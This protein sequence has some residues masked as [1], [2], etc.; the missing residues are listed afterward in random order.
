MSPENNLFR[1]FLAQSFRYDPEANY[2]YLNNAK[3]GCSTIKAALWKHHGKLNNLDLPETIPPKMNHGEGFWSKDYA[4]I[5]SQSPYIFS[6]VRNPYTRVLSAYLDK[7]CKPGILRSQFYLQNNIPLDADIS[8]SEFLGIIEE[9][10]CIHDQHWR[11]QSENLLI[12]SIPVSAVVQLESLNSARQILEDGLG[13]SLT[14]KTMAGH[15]TS[16]NERVAGYYSQKEIEQVRRIY[17]MDFELFDYSEDIAE[18][19]KT[20]ARA[21]A[22]PEFDEMDAEFIKLENRSVHGEARSVYEELLQRERTLGPLPTLFELLKHWLSLGRGGGASIEAMAEHFEPSIGDHPP[23]EQ[24]W[25]HLILAD[26]SSRR[27][28]MKQAREHL[29]QLI[30]LSPSIQGPRIR[31]VESLIESENIAEA[32]D[33]LKRLDLVTWNKETVAELLARVEQHATSDA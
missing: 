12:G 8:F 33:E 3:S 17:K 20:H 16:A 23:L 24:Y 15:S 4:G 7:I 27:R 21:M 30:A 9:N 5:F 26:L 1:P 25:F 28:R 18:I 11:R 31:L 2:V 32:R 13:F 29:R 14:L 22:F 19:G 10:Q 6:V